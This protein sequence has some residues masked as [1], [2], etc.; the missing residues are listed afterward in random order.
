MGALSFAVGTLGESVRTDCAIGTGRPDRC[1]LLRQG[2]L[3]DRCGLL[4]QGG[5]ARYR[6]TLWTLLALNCILLL[7]VDR[8]LQK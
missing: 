2:R 1:P 4:G 8:K 6:Y 7:E 3:P 5:S